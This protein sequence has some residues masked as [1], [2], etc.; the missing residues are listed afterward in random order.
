MMMMIVS[1]HKESAA[2]A[3][4]DDDYDLAVDVGLVVDDE[5]GEGLLVWSG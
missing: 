5:V 4:D 1:F 2:A 3:A